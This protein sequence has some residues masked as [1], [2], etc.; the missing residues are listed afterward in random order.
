MVEQ[1]DTA[2]DAASAGII[3]AGHQWAHAGIGAQHASTPKYRSQLFPL[4]QQRVDF[5]RCDPVVINF[6]VRDM[7][8]RRA[9]Q[10]NGIAGHQNIGIG[11]FTAAVDDL[12][13]DTMV[14]DQQR[15][16]GRE[17]GDAQI[18]IFR[19]PLSPDPG[20]IDHNPGV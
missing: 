4:P 6:L 20:S 11:R 1:N 9:N 10:R 17:H 18:G 12:S 7:F 5:G 15:S 3:I 13:V 8:R 14:E 16:L 19:D 2:A